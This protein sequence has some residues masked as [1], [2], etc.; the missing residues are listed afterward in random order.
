M[1][2]KEMISHQLDACGLDLSFIIQEAFLGYK[3]RKYNNQLYT[4]DNSNIP[5]KLIKMYYA[6]NPDE[7][8]F[9]KMKSAFVSRYVLNES[10]LEGVNDNDAHGL[11]E[12][13]GFKKMYEYI[14][15]D[16]IEYKF[17][18]YTL[19]DL[20]KILFSC[21][22]YPEYAGNFRNGLAY[23]PGSR[24]ELT[25]YT[26]IRPMLNELDKTVQ[27]LRKYSK[28]IKDNGD[29]NMLFDYLDR[30]VELNVK[31]IKVHPFADGNGRTIRGFTNKLLEDVGFPPIYVKASEHIEYD[32]AL[33]LANNEGDFDDIKNFYRY[34]I[35]D[36]IIEL[37]INDRV[38]KYNKEHKS[39][40]K[41]K[42]KVM[43]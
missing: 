33:D 19:K 41:V 31:L 16:E 35:C 18:I 11:E 14:H 43:E 42:T 10:K 39:M 17:D 27:Y 40:G 13:E 1:S 22:Q 9:D 28:L 6:L 3:Y 7:I 25:D 21:S 34:K 29:V 8:V 4:V 30:C 26:M 36:S 37:D 20:H 32:N 5:E 12:I 24:V 15:S 38:R 2:E 23:L